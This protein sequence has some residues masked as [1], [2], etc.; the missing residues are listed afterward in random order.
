[1]VGGGNTIQIDWKPA[2]KLLIGLKN[3]KT[4]HIDEIKY[5]LLASAYD[6][7]LKVKQKGLSIIRINCKV[8]RKRTVFLNLPVSILR[9]QEKRS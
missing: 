7:S 3:H 5:E 8:V 9:K 6:T 1:M 2:E 4:K